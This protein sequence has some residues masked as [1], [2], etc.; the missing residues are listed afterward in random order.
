[1][2]T[3]LVTYTLESFND[4]FS[5]ISKRIKEYPKWARI[6]QYAWLI[7]PDKSVSDVRSELKTAINEKGTILVI[8]VSSATW[9]TFAINKQV[10][11]WMKENL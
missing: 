11:D 10:T 7:Q 5:V 1:M 6:S 9:A 2:K 4:S 8:D 3:F